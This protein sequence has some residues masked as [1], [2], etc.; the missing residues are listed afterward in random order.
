MLEFCSGTSDLERE[1]HKY[2]DGRPF[3]IWYF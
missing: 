3:K 1:G 2:R